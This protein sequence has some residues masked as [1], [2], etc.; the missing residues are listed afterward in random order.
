MNENTII[1]PASVVML[2]ALTEGIK[3]FSYHLYFITDEY[4]KKGEWVYDP[5]RNKL[6]KINEDLTEKS[7]FGAKKII[8]TTN[9]ELWYKGPFNEALQRKTYGDI[10]KIDTSFVK[11]YVRE[12]GK[13][14]KVLLEYEKIF[15]QTG[16]TELGSAIGYTDI[17]LK[18]KSNG[19]VIVH[20]VKEKTYTR[21]E[22][23]KIA[24]HAHSHGYNL[25]LG[26]SDMLE[27][28]EWFSKNYPE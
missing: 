10:P 11:A 12:H 23:E 17:E 15:F 28:K 3:I 5:I 19:S 8:A 6:R 21:D 2:P 14:D 26:A 20:R 16:S 22:V 13:I 27:F 18:L 9:P 25:C 24:V 4:A 1:K 7:N